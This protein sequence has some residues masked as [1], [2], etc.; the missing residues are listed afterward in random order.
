MDRL[1]NQSEGMINDIG[2]HRV[3]YRWLAI[4]SQT[5]ASTSEA[6]VPRQYARAQ[7][8]KTVEMDTLAGLI[9]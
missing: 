6:C 7:G 1:D 4:V 9:L 2:I 3:C 5:S 8:N